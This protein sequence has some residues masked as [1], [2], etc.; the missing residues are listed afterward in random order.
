MRSKLPRVS[1]VRLVMFRQLWLASVMHGQVCS[2]SFVPHSKGYSTAWRPSPSFTRNLIESVSE[3]SEALGFEG[4]ADGLDSAG[5]T[6]G[7]FAE[8]FR[9]SSRQIGQDAA[10]AVNGASSTD[11][12]SIANRIRTAVQDATDDVAARTQAMVSTEVTGAPLNF[13]R[14][15]C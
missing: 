8:E 2:T 3:V 11:P 15:G 6:V 13:C 10:E 7:T 14:S 5:Q 4:A 9:R 12:N 1:S